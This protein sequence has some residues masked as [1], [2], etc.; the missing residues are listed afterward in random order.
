MHNFVFIPLRKMYLMKGIIS[1]ALILTTLTTMSQIQNIEV[2][3]NPETGL[4]EI[5][6]VSTNTS[7]SVDWKEGESIIY[8]G[9]PMCSWCWGISPQLNALKRY[10][11]QE[12]IPFDIVMGGLRPGGGD[13]W[14]PK[15]QSFLKH[16][17]E[18]V[19]KRSGQPF[20]FDLLAK[21]Y[22]NYDTEPA[23]RAVVTARSIAPEKAVQF[24]ELVQHSFYVKS[25]DPKELEFYQSICDE[26][27]LDYQEFSKKFNSEEMIAATQN[28]FLQNRQW[29]VRGFPTVI[30]K[31][32][33]QLH[34]IARGYADYAAMKQAIE[35]IS[36][37][38][39]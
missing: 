29:G 8:V 34:L 1:L 14:N 10:G 11:E 17:W 35:R 23:C 30:Y 9:D 6:D 25:K 4:C 12:G 24:Y 31:K 7:L 13:E 15:F 21:D 28:D 38:D 5:P 16:H 20:N 39:D 26:L 37:S 19:N 2:S 18:E 32:N 22:F 27:S 3:C 33:D 36:E